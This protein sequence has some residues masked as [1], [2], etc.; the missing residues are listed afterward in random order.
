MKAIILAGGKGTRLRPLTFS[1]PKPLLPVGEKPILELI[2]S[3][4]KENG[5]TEISLAV[6]YKAELIRTYFGDGEKFGVNLEYFEEIKPLGTAGPL[7]EVYQKKKFTEPVLVMNGDL[8]TQLDFKKMF[9]FHK[10]SMADMTVGVRNH[11]IKSPFGVVELEGDKVRAIKEKPEI[12]QIVGAGIY[13]INPSVLEK[14]PENQYYDLPD[15]I[16]DAI[17]AKKLVLGYPISEYW[18]AIDQ[19][20]HIDEAILNE[21]KWNKI[22]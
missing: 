22:D 14:I 7:K 17:G 1:I 20:S 5:I 16:E 8:I 19:I 13:I 6:G 3:R 21:D 4:L 12:K 10:Q 11:S 15:L 2:L 18:I 9:A